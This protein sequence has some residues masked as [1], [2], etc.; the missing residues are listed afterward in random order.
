MSSRRKERKKHAADNNNKRAGN[1]NNTAA[2]QSR[3]KNGD[4]RQIACNSQAA[5]VNVQNYHSQR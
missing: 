1:K 2:M 3:L 4:A 5:P